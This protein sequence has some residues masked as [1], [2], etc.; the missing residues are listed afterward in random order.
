M[1]KRTLIDVISTK[2]NNDYTVIN[3][4]EKG[5]PPPKM[6]IKLSLLNKHARRHSH[7][8][9]LK[10]FCLEMR[11]STY[12]Y[13]IR[14]SY[15]LPDSMRKYIYFLIYYITFKSIQLKIR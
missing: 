15:I 5:C 7:Y 13:L 10:S 3:Q 6:T 12:L 9:Y 8:L 1:Y 14:Y 11:F 4:M 2:L